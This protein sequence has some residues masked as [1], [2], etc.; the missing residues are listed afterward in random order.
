[1][2][3]PQCGERLE[4]GRPDCP[5]CFTPVQ[6]PGLLRR[7]WDFLFKADIPK[8]TAG[9]LVAGKAIT[10]ITLVDRTTGKRQ[11]FDSLNALPPEI[12]AKFE[13]AQALNRI[14]SRNLS[15]TFQGVDGQAQTYH[16]VEEMPADV[17]AAYEELVLPEIC[18]TLGIPSERQSENT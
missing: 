14:D 9:T 4:E 8:W 12:R 15:F 5:V 17:R 3:C 11:V 13:E 16:S 18:A 2:F 10:N 7:L 6:K 1:M